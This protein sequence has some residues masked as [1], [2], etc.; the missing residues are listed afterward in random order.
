MG[1]TILAFI[2]TPPP[3][4]AALE[5]AGYDVRSIQ[6]VGGREALIEQGESARIALTNGEGGLSGAEI[7]RLP[8]LE[9]ICA[10]GVGYEE[11]DL[12]MARSRG[13][14]VTN[15]RGT[16]DSAVADHALALMLTVASGIVPADAMVRS[17]DWGAFAA[18]APTFPFMDRRRGL[19]GKRLGILGLGQIGTKI[20]ARCYLGFE[21]PVA[22]HARNAV[23]GS[24]YRYMAAV[25][26]LAEWSD[27]LVVAAPGGAG[28]H[29]L[30]DAGALAA[31]GP[32]GFLINIGRGGVVDTV[33]LIAA[34]R[35]GAIGGAGLDVVEGEPTIP[36]ELLEL[37]NV[38][39]TPH[40]AGRGPEP[41]Q[42]MAELLVKNI[43]AFL[44][45]EPVLTPI[46]L[47]AMRD[48]AV[49]SSR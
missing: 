30:V 13:I 47:P 14:T 29:H 36:P 34:L 38:V 25:R 21:M 33:A 32:D 4:R 16:N 11:I 7:A 27:F 3:V 43:G 31:L 15:G 22:Y 20:A 12:D 18:G 35:S 1:E 46:L 23:P 24:P 42:V 49:S 45:G 39:L 17:G 6:D 9:L 2:P 37:D 26:E 48:H 28:T 5:A 41:L 19:F 44:A 8:K 40:M 10:I